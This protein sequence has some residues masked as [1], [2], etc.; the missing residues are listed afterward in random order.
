VQA[1][2][3]L[4]AGDWVEVRSKDEILSTLDADGELEGMPFMP[5]MA[6]WCGQRFQVYKSA[7]KTCDTVFPI[8][9]RR[10]HRAVHLATRCSGEAH[11][12]CQA[13]C[14]LFWK[15][16]WLKPASSVPAVESVVRLVP[17]TARAAAVATCSESTLRQRAMRQDDSG[18]GPIYSCQATRLPDATSALPWWDVR[19][20]I[21]DY[22]SGNVGLR[23]MLAGLCY[24]I[25]WNI[26]EAGVGLGRPMQFLYDKL[27]PLWR[28]TLFPRKTGT[29]PPG[30]PTPEADLNLQ[31][32]E[33]VRVKPHAE[34]LKTLSTG[35]KNRGLWWD[36]EMV[37]YCGG[38]YRVLQRVR[39]IIDEKTGRMLVMKTP[40]ITLE[41]VFCQS[42]YSACRMFCPRSIPSYW[43][44]IWLERV[45][46]P[47]A[48]AVPAAAG[49][50][51]A[52]NDVSFD[53]A[54]PQS[55]A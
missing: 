35:S 38:T 26:S 12:G 31:P 29:I 41:H 14:L 46:P 43:R 50:R 2:T 27:H 32:G 1:R 36:A 37:P 3:R 44:E 8:R 24:S 25:F 55:Q 48:Q 52:C 22:R 21:D 42:R 6:A 40:C 45:E 16:A 28:G 17:R 47:Q 18:R 19:Q 9:G 5:E 53:R 51:A 13:A 10:V 39:R 7:H 11:G 54:H 15:E 34:I 33:W 49:R 20:Y 30:Q 4:R 23:R